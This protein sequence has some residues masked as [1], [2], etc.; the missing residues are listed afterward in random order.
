MI[1]S[2]YAIVIATVLFLFYFLNL[3][4]FLW[5]GCFDFNSWLW[6]FLLAMIVIVSVSICSFLPLIL[7]LIS[8]WIKRHNSLFLIQDEVIYIFFLDT[9]RSMYCS[10]RFGSF[11][12]S[13]S[14]SIF[15]KSRIKHGNRRNFPAWSEEDRI[16]T[17]FCRPSVSFFLSC[18]TRCIAFW[19]STWAFFNKKIS[20]YR[21]CH[22]V[23]IK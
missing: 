1:I 20:Y 9:S 3:A 10:L 19:V 5:F 11:F 18:C 23:P 14:I 13:F 4:F 15:F 17:K 6:F 7:F 8:L 2:F 21:H 12:L 22:S 16:R